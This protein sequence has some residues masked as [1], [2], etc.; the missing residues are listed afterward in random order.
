MPRMGRFID[1][2]FSVGFT[3]S[4]QGENPGVSHKMR[5]SLESFLLHSLLSQLH[6]RHVPIASSGAVS[7]FVSCT[8]NQG[9]GQYLYRVVLLLLSRESI[10][11]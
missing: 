11:D 7:I 6:R 2:L 3:H 8:G 9:S 5:T 1:N 10:I 4:V